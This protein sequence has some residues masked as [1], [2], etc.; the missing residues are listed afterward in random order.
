MLVPRGLPIIPSPL[1]ETGKPPAPVGV[2][3]AATVAPA[4]A[5]APTIVLINAPIIEAGAALTNQISAHPVLV[6]KAPV[7]DVGLHRP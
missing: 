7:K 5:V 6:G 1:V 2:M 4:R 3:P